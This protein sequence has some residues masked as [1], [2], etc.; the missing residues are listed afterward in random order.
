M[1]YIG[2][3]DSSLPSNV[4]KLPASQRTKWVAVWNSVFKK[5][6]ADKGSTGDCEKKA[7]SIANSKLKKELSMGQSV[8]VPEGT[9]AKEAKMITAEGGYVYVPSNIY[10]F[11]AFEAYKAV[12]DSVD[13][14]QEA[15]SLFSDLAR[16]IVWSSDVVDKEGALKTLV[17]EFGA[18][19]S[20]SRTAKAR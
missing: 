13:R 16:N 1:P 18:Y 4:K 9:E 6:M 3:S 15:T 10:S 8:A 7:F 17:S 14:L 12:E 20:K 5:C 19:L 11:S 2:A